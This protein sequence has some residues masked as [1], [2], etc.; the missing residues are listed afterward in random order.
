MQVEGLF[1]LKYFIDLPANAQCFSP[2]T[3]IITFPVGTLSLLRQQDWAQ[4]LRV[5]KKS[6]QP[7]RN[8]FSEIFSL[9]T[10][11]SKEPNFQLSP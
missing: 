1:I 11:L 2:D 9:S 3:A 5:Q 7:I 8:G 10:C 6:V 4:R